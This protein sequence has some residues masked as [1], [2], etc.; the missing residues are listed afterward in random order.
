MKWY[1]KQKRRTGEE[2]KI[3]CPSLKIIGFDFI[4]LSSFQNRLLG[5]KAH[6]EFLLKND[7]LL[8]ED[9]NL[10]NLQNIS[11]TS[12]IA[13]PLLLDGIDGSPITILAE[14]K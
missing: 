12:I 4:S 3:K 5:R 13:L 10:D 2:I 6:Y 9:M 7:I 8:I 1:W 14:Y 11:I